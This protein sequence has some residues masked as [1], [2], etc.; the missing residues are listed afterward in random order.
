M[1]SI[2]IIISAWC[3]KFM[4]KVETEKEDLREQRTLITGPSAAVAFMQD[5]YWSC[6]NAGPQVYLKFIKKDIYFFFN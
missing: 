4:H 1:A 3:I 2:L 6:I 5:Q